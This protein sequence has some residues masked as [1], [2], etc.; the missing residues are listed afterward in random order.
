MTERE[1]V[2]FLKDTAAEYISVVERLQRESWQVGDK[3]R[4]ERWPNAKAML[5]PFAMIQMADAWLAV[6]AATRKTEEG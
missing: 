3:E 2:Q 1:Y 4:M 5:S 6:N